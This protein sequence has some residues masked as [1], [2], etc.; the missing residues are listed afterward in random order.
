MPWTRLLFALAGML[1][2][3][4]GCRPAP[5]VTSIV[6]WTAEV[7]QD[8]VEVQQGLARRFAQDH[9]DV[10]V[11]VVPVDENVLPE[12]LASA[13]AA[14]QLPDVVELGLPQ[15]VQYDRAG[16]L[17]RDAATRL[18]R[19]LGEEGFYP[20]P[21]DLVRSGEGAGYAA[22]PVDG[23]VQGIWY[24]KDWFAEKGLSPPDTWE[25]IRTAAEALHAPGEPRF[26]IVL[27]T[28]PQQVYTQQVFEHLALAGGARLVDETGR[29]APGRRFLE[30]LRFYRRLA[31]FAAPGHTYWREARQ[32]YL[33]G[34]A[35]MIFYSPYILDDLAG[36]VAEHRPAVP[37]LAGRTGFVA[38][39]QGPSGER[40]AYGEVY[41]LGILR[42]AQPPAAQ[43]AAFLLGP[44]YPEW[45][46]MAP[47]G[48]MP[49]R[50]Q[51]LT[52]W[53]EQALFAPYD[54]KLPDALAEGFTR[55]ARWGFGRPGGGRLIGD[56]YAS[57]RVP[58]MIGRL[59]DDREPPEKA[60]EWFRA[61]LA[62]LAARR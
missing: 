49:V 20:G 27:G 5:K 7:E 1:A 57:K 25:R 29:P 60:L 21:L 35:A 53:R 38:A 36:L 48:K 33:T 10:E 13:R 45:L 9:P 34:R 37:D 14:G 3:A 23:W 59:L 22:V 30:A 24:R 8:R 32:Y 11:R 55:L 61:R 28:H 62:E 44:G 15:V 19:E 54:P 12:K 4:A 6:F 43:W 26:G 51:A 17:D 42:G 18:I 47:G 16:L 56:L 39:I 50:R 46:S 58:E 31:R 2:L 40:A 41:A 52:R